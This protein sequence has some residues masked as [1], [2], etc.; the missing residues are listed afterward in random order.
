M[1][2]LL[3]LNKNT[4]TIL[5]ER[6]LQNFKFI[7]PP[8]SNENPYSEIIELIK[9]LVQLNNLLK[10]SDDYVIMKLDTG[11]VVIYRQNPSNNLAVVLI[12]EKKSYK[13][14]SLTIISK[15][16]LDNLSYDELTQQPNF[17]VKDFGLQSIEEL[18]TK[19]IDYL[20]SNKL[21]PKFFYFNYNPNASNSIQ[22]KK[23]QLESRSVILY[24]TSKEYDQV[25]EQK[26][27]L[28][29]KSTIKEK[30]LNIDLDK[31]PN[32]PTK[33]KI[34]IK[35]YNNI[36][37]DQLKKKTFSKSLNDS[38]FIEKFF[39]TNNNMIHMLFNNVFIESPNEGNSLKENLNFPINQDNDHVLLFLLDLYDKAQQMFGVT[40]N[41]QTEY[42]DIVNYIELNL[43]KPEVLLTKN[44]LAFIKYKSLFIA[45]QIE[46]YEDKN[47]WT[48]INANTN[49]YKEI[50]SLF[51]IIYN[52]SYENGQ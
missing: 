40:K 6:K 26:D 13:K 33:K 7:T 22:S 41:G 23:T 32:N 49:F 34:F 12:C 46:I 4:F 14:Q 37:L 48:T 20:R 43:S 19:F 52:S 35:K 47:Y 8:L 5:A 30:E 38:Y 27:T 28:L 10:P 1:E 45:I 16:L 17:K 31:K 11:K 24:N 29:Q 36:K 50:E 39:L 42:L 25:H 2:T 15:I 51:S 18:T 21:F 9:D 44:K 3:L